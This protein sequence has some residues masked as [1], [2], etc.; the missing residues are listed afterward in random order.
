MQDLIN[1]L[2]E[3]LGV[4]AG[5]AKSSLGSLLSIIKGE[6]DSGP[7]QEM[8][9]KMPGANELAAANS[10]GGGGGGGLL[11]TI[12]GALGGL[13]GGGGGAGGI[14]GLVSSLGPDKLK[15]LVTTFIGYAK[16]MAGEETVNKVINSVPGLKSIL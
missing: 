6:G 9:D 14:A 12:K 10:G 4:D 11:G 3:K 5:T 16:K 2:T 7:V 15:D 8:F 1:S 13:G